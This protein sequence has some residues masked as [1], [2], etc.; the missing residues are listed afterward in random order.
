MNKYT[1]LGV[2]VLAQITLLY[3]QL[4]SSKPL[5]Q[6]SISQA[7]LTIEK[8]SVTAVS[9]LDADG[10]EVRLQNVDQGWQ[11]GDGFSAQ[12]A[13]VEQLIEKI[14]SL[15][16]N[17]ATAHT[18]TAAQRFQVSEDTFQRKLTIETANSKKIQLFVGSG[19]G[20]RRSHVRLASEK[21]IYSLPLAEYELSTD[22]SDWQDINCLRLATD[23]IKL[24]EINNL[25]L[26]KVDGDGVQAIE[27]TEDGAEDK[28]TTAG[29]H[30]W[31]GKDST[32][33][34]DIQSEAVVSAVRHL[35]QL[36]IERAEP[37]TNDLFNERLSLSLQ[38]DQGNRKYQLLQSTED[39]SEYWIQASDFEGFALHISETN[40][41][42]ILAN[43][44]LAKL[45]D[46]AEVTSPEPS[47]ETA[48]DTAST[49][50]SN[51]KEIESNN[52]TAEPDSTVLKA[53]TE[54]DNALLS[55]E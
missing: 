10:T 46:S 36:R 6:H 21:A 43:W 52:S 51:P 48:V 53:V 41:E 37:S 20:A 26:L 13:S 33:E 55:E 25:T 8:E 47:S 15:K 39:T 18:D 23:T 24:V 7:L 29:V 9:I 4:R 54:G 3:Y 27:P 28:N 44:A 49:D 34:I 50:D 38:H 40:A 30:T 45:T 17:L 12:Q 16:T 22:A 5:A 14:S 32:G 11:T 35:S 42:Q 2:L 1:I 19:A 31:I